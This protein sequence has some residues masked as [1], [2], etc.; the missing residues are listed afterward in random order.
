MTSTTLTKQTS[1]ASAHASADQFLE[2]LLLTADIQINGTRPWDIKLLDK[3]VPREV[4]SGGSLALGEAFMDGRW[5]CEALDEFFTKVLRARLD[6]QVRPSKIL[7]VMLREKLL[8]RQSVRRAWEVGRRHYDLGNDFYSAM[9]DRRMTYTCGY[10]SA[11]AQSLNSAQEDKLDL[12]C[13]K[14]QLKPGM[15]LLDIGC[16]WGSLMAFAAEYYGVTCVGVTISAEQA[17]WAKSRYAGLPLEFRLQDYRSLDEKFDRIASV[18]MFEHVGAKNY[19][20]YM[21]VASRCLTE[22][23]LFLL[24]TIGK[25]RAHTRPDPWIDRYI[26]PNGELPALDQIASAASGLFITEDVHNFGADYDR[27]LMAWYANFE[28]E[29]PRFEEQ[30]GERFHRMWKYYLLSCAGLFR[31]REAQLWQWVFSKRGV[32]GGYHR[33]HGA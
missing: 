27:T 26:F 6:E 21:R 23:G 4:I 7:Y 28:R 9:L 11:G 17:E 16:G 20:T 29:W 12:I 32:A 22:S 13:R 25:N 2:E 19:R 1:A 24:H 5:E 10:W 14:L 18:G 8:N 15:R 33:P 31:A 30:M 3:D